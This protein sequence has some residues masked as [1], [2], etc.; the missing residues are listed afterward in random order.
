MISLTPKVSAIDHVKFAIVT[1]FD[2]R[3]RGR[4]PA[5][6]LILISCSK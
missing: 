2:R 5:L 1:D 6:P 4:A 3:I